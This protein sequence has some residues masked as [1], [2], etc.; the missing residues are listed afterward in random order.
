MLI[1]QSVGCDG[2]YPAV[3][4]AGLLNRPLCGS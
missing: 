3:V 4:E 1:E 2:Y